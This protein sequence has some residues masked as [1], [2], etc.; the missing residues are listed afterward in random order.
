MTEKAKFLLVVNKERVVMMNPSVQTA[1]IIDD[2][3]DL[4]QLLATI[5][6]ARKIHVLITQTLAEAEN[7]LSY[8]KPTVV[9]LDNSFPEGLGINFIRNIKSADEEIKII[10]M[11]GDSSPWIEEKAKEEGVNYFLK[12]PFSKNLIDFVLDKLK[13][14]K[15]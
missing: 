15:K 14:R 9:F 3:R 5:L 13:F 11:T 10:M 4:S 8:L 2:D 7:Y 12:K 6:E 1:M